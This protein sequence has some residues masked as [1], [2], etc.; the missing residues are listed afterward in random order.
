MDM[1]KYFQEISPGIVNEEWVDIS[2]EPDVFTFPLENYV[3]AKG[4]QPIRAMV[5]TILINNPSLNLL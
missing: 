4:G 1:N 5:G 3:L 2:S